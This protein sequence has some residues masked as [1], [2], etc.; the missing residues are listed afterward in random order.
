MMLNAAT[1][2]TTAR[3]RALADE[4]AGPALRSV[5]LSGLLAL[6]LFAVLLAFAVFVPIAAGTV[7]QGLVAV[8]GERKVVQHSGG[9]IVADILVHEGVS[10]RQGDIVLKLNAVQAGAAAGVI[11]SQLGSLRAEEAVRTAEVT[12]TAS[13]TFPPE[14]LARSGDPKVAAIL[15]AEQAA[16]VARRDL[17]RSQADQLDQQL[18]Q[19]DR[20]SASARSEK[21]S[22]LAQAALLGEELASLR[23]LLEKGLAI[24]SRVLALERSLE[25][26][27]GQ[28]ES[29]V[30]EEGRLAARAAE[31]RGLRARI[32]V[33]RRAEAAEA[34]RG[35]RARIAETLD[36]QLATSDTLQRMDVRAPIDGV[37]MALR[38]NTIGGVVEPGQPLMEIV[39]Q[40]ER[41]VARVRISPQD[42]DNVRQGMVALVRFGAGSARAPAQAEGVVQA[43]SADA[44][45]DERT[46]ASYF[47]VWVAI[48]VE[49]AAK[50]PKDLVAPGLPVEVLIRSGEH[51]ILSYLFSPIESAMFRMIRD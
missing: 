42:A 46:G 12:G 41:L 13:V 6:L 17:A 14:L 29:L 34:L 24:R 45:A 26:A 27:R 44:L 31:T 43:I 20:S 40:D 18:M 30:A 39:P 37:V 25:A 33:D 38:V 9:G 50:V 15:A 35:L 11:D 5:R 28:A 1:D 32:D 19:I 51:T 22:Q 49:E 48:P 23:P 16:F 2:E 8:D 21:E 36:R 7:A 3:R 4:L 10:V 47:E